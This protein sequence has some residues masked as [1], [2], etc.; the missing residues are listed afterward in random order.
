[1]HEDTRSPSSGKYET[2][3]VSVA[4]LFT[5]LLG[6]AL[7]CAVAALALRGGLKWLKARYGGGSP[8]TQESYLPGL[9]RIPG[10]RLQ[11]NEPEDLRV[12]LARQRERLESYGTTASDRHIPIER[13]ME[14]LSHE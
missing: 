10:P 1:M 8:K 6:L 3:D 12:S 2:K 7:I 4:G 14:R 11:V 13:A 5:A 9:L